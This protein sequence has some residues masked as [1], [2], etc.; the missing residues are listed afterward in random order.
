MKMFLIPTVACFIAAIIVTPSILFAIFSNFSIRQETR[1]LLLGN[2]LISDLI[3]LFLYTTTC[4]CTVINLKIP[5]IACAFLLF[6]LAVTYCGGV[7]TA[8]GMV[9]DT[10]LAILWPLHYFSLLPPSRA[11]RLLI[12]LWVSSSILP[13]IL[14]L[15]LYFTQK[16]GPCHPDVCSLP[17]ILL[18]TLHAD[19]TVRLFHILFITAFLLSFSL[20][21]CCYLVLCFK[22]RGTGI[23]KGVSSR[24]SVTFSMHHAILGFHFL[25]MLILLAESLLYIN[26]MMDLRTGMML[27]S[28]ICNVLIVLPKGVS[29]YLYGFR[30]R[31]IYK[32]LKLFCKFKRP[33]LVSPAQRYS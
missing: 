11:K 6:S 28:I 22:T 16:T 19:E 29:P 4:V 14:F 13:A 20:I 10:Y 1:F 31:K 27:T 32:S 25:P 24:A 3:Y 23:W 7:L 8:A 33:H 21:L 12:L 15:V 18:M 9:I 26:E 5:N 17:V 30:Y 2:A